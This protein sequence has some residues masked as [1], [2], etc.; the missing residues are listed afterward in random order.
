MNEEPI[1][2]GI[3]LRFYWLIAWRSL[4]MYFVAYGAFISWL[5]VTE[6]VDDGNYFFVRIALSLLLWFATSFVAVRMALRKRYRDFRIQITR[7]PAS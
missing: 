6:R 3:T 5:F 1:T 7:E 2:W 4:A